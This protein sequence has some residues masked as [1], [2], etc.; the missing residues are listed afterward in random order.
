MGAERVRSL[1][2]HELNVLRGVLRDTREWPGVAITLHL[3]A[4]CHEREPCGR[5]VPLRLVVG[6]RA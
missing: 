5:C 6:A 3:D 4:A 2:G 1:R